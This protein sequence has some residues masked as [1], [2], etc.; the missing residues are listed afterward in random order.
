MQ[1]L[2]H[3]PPGT[4]CP[5][6]PPFLVKPWN[7]NVVESHLGSQGQERHRSKSKANKTEGTWVP[8][9]ESRAVILVKA[10]ISELLQKA[11]E[12]CTL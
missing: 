6:L 2:G 5:L 8:D 1:I 4:G 9:Q 11:R 7:V 3:V 10:A 12:V